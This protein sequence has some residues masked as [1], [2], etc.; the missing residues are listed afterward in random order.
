[1]NEFFHSFPVS[2]RKVRENVERRG[3]EGLRKAEAR[4]VGGHVPPCRR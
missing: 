1:M 2:S 4:E 3:G